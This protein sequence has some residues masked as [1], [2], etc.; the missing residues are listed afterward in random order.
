MENQNESQLNKAYG[1]AIYLLGLRLRTEGELREKLIIKKYE[2]GITN[3]VITQLKE[4]RYIDDQRYAEI[5]L[6][7]LKKY[8]TFGYFGIKKK[9][10]ERRLPNI[11][12]ESV[13]SEG[14]SE[15]EEEKI[16]K[17]FI[18]NYELGIMN[19]EQKQKLAHKLKSRGFRGSVT[20]KLIF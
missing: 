20:A 13:L 17:R 6:E 5:Y 8:K 4:N 19:Y 9:L 1:Y 12:I 15:E 14:M 10:M 2:L 7:N 18:K 3:Q 11:I 16:A